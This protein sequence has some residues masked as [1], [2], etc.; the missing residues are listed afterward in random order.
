MTDHSHH[1]DLIQSISEQYSEIL[2]GSNQGVYIY[3]D[4]EHKVCNKNF[5]DLLGYKSEEE[6]A[7]IDS[8][9]PT[10][11]VADESQE[12]LVSAFQDAMD[13][14]TAST[15]EIVWKKKDGD[16]VSTKVILVPVVH[17]G[18]LFAL[19]FVSNS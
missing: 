4:D 15:S 11:F 14:M 8:S 13:N 6:W 10:A 2:S 16:T 1:N 7:Q 12:T 5:S 17:D 9:F 18:H 19:H 3:L